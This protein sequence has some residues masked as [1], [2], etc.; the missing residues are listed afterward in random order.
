MKKSSKLLPLY[1]LLLF[2]GLLTTYFVVNQTFS[3]RQQSYLTFGTQAETFKPEKTIQPTTSP[4]NRLLQLDDKEI[5]Q[6]KHQSNPVKLIHGKLSPGQIIVKFKKVSLPQTETDLKTISLGK[7]P[8]KDTASKQLKKTLQNVGVKSYNL[9]LK[10]TD[11]TLANT[12]LLK[13][14][15]NAD[16]IKTVNNLK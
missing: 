3:L 13:L 2:L 6:Q 7:F 15:P 5:E 14:A 10:S 4:P 1:T 16:V 9:L 11:S 12:Y 8:E